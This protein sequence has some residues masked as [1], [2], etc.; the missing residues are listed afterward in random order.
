MVSRRLT[1]SALTI[2][3]CT[4]LGCV[5]SMDVPA[6]ISEYCNVTHSHYPLR[7]SRKDT[8]ETKRQVA[9]ANTI[10]ERL[11]NAPASQ[12]QKP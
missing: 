2:M 5:S 10:Y 4:T 11:C 1:L 3:T 9:Q 7:P 8:P 6:A 12:T